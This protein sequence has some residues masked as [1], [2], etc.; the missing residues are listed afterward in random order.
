MEYKDEILSS[1]KNFACLTHGWAVGQLLR[2][3]WIKIIMR[4]YLRM[5]LTLLMP[6][7][8][9]IHQWTVWSLVQEMIYQ[10]FHAKLLPEPM[11]YY[12]NQTGRKQTSGKFE[13]I[14]IILLEIKEIKMSLD[15][16]KQNMSLNHY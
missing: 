7:I 3:L 11:T 13:S 9:Y 5:Q 4:Y 2:D 14:K 10:L 15:D 6:G 12:V 16:H 8:T 1:Q